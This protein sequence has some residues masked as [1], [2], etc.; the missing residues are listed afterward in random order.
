[1]KLNQETEYAI[2]MVI[3]CAEHNPNL[4]S[5]TFIVETCNV[6]NRWGKII[7]TTLCSKKILNSTKGKNGGFQLNKA[8]K[9]ISLFDIISIFESIAI[10]P[11]TKQCTSNELFRSELLNI[12]SYVE[13]QLKNITINNLI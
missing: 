7:L 9:S 3:L 11:D 6:P 4:L 1:M 8:P 13:T 5:G 10:L 2:R 12:K